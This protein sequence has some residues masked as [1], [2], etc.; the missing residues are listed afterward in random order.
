MTIVL[1]ERWYVNMGGRGTFAAGNNVAYSYETVGKI[2]KGKSKSICNQL[3]RGIILN[4]K[5]E[6][7]TQPILLIDEY[8]IRSVRLF[9]KAVPSL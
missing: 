8:F 6:I 1:L 4:E 2:E 5:A 7:T 9:S 3:S